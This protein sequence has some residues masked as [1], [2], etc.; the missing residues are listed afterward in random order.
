MERRGPRKI[1]RITL[2]S[3]AS[4]KDSDAAPLWLSWRTLNKNAQATLHPSPAFHALT[5]SEREEEGK[6]AV[7]YQDG[8]SCSI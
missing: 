5:T 2:A 1:G 4:G 7:H 6:G 8:L 3:G